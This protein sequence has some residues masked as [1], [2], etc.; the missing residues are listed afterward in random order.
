MK[1]CKPFKGSINPGQIIDPIMLTRFL[2]ML[3]VDFQDEILSEIDSRHR[4]SIFIDDSSG[5]IPR[6]PKNEVGNNP[7]KK[8]LFF[9]DFL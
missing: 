8:S 4:E 6:L 2:D 7:Q 9:K 3:G 1:H 5:F